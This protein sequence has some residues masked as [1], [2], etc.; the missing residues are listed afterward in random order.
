MDLFAA[1][2]AH[3]DHAVPSLLRRATQA[4][5]GLHSWLV[6]ESASVSYGRATSYL[7]MIDP[8]RYFEIRI[9][10]TPGRSAME[11]NQ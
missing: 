1:P 8:H 10:M 7:L 3:E 6:L 5:G 11:W 9:E 4:G 2:I